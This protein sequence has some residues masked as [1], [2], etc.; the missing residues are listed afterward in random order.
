MMM[1]KFASRLA[2]EDKMNDIEITLLIILTSERLAA[3]HSSAQGR[4]DQVNS[5]GIKG[6]TITLNITFKH[7]LLQ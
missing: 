6:E 3:P 4:Q 2:I 5:S 1:L 7:H